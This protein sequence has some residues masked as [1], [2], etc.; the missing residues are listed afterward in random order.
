MF[1]QVGSK[2]R[3]WATDPYSIWHIHAPRDPYLHH[4]PGRLATQV[5]QGPGKV[6]LPLPLEVIAYILLHVP[7]PNL[8]FFYDNLPAGDS[9]RLVIA[10]KLYENVHYGQ[11]DPNDQSRYHI[12]ISELVGLAR[13]EIK[14]LIRSLSFHG[15]QNDA[16]LSFCIRYPVFVSQIP[17]IEFDG[18]QEYLRS[19][20][21]NVPL[22]NMFKL[23]FVEADDLDMHL[24]PPNLKE[25]FLNFNDLSPPVFKRWPSKLRTL[26]IRDC[27]SVLDIE[28]P[29]GLELLACFDS[30]ELW[31]Q[32]P[33]GLKKL[34][35][36]SNVDTFL[37][38]FT[39]PD[40]LT[41]LTF[42][43][44][45][46]EDP[47][48]VLLQWPTS[49]KRLDLSN[50][51]ITSLVGVSLPRCLEVLRL[52]FCQIYTLENVN[53][54]SL[55]KQLYLKGNPLSTMDNVKLPNLRILDISANP[56]SNSE[57]I[58]SLSKVQFPSLLEKLVA[59]DQPVSDWSST[60]LPTGLK[61]LL[62][63]TSEHPLSLTFPPT[64]EVLHLKFPES[65]DSSIFDLKL[66]TTLYLLEVKNGISKRIPWNLPYLK[67][68]TMV[69]LTGNVLIPD[70]VKTLSLESQDWS[71][72]RNLKVPYGVEKL[73]VSCLL[74]EYPD[75]VVDLD[76]ENFDT[77]GDVQM[78]LQLR[79]LRVN[80]CDFTGPI[81][82]ENL[83]L[84]KTLQRLEG[85]VAACLAES[86][87]W[88]YKIS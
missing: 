73:K 13:G 88:K 16:F 41:D 5:L 56:N 71:L 49:L 35:L 70:T 84:P 20:A 55:L 32:F 87:N 85:D 65:S 17:Q 15:Y 69:N 83:K 11:Y 44:D 33:P 62:I 61:V 52:E 31:R 66:P 54:P 12:S 68:M 6:L 19:Y 23:R 79:S 43:S 59:E 75:T 78:P 40:Q 60:L 3:H 21:S 10:S 4:R 47:D 80:T 18:T 77:H 26:E 39:F 50:N 45:D 24:I 48:I 29:A 86:V 74:K 38:D 67:D 7:Y 2:R 57:N 25:V 63:Q 36:V 9:L 42:D 8:K 58:E 72:F 22:D 76:I 1:I 27:E 37:N 64:L 81:P 30:G 53:L 51:A 28:L 14:A 46:F 82:E 34:K